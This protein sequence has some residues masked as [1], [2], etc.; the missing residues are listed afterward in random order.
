[1]MTA[2]QLL[3]FDATRKYDDDGNPDYNMR[4]RILLALRFFDWATNEEISDYLGFELRAG[5]VDSQNYHQHMCRLVKLGHVKR[6]GHKGASEY[7]L[8]LRVKPAPMVKR[9]G[10]LG[11][12]KPR[13]ITPTTCRKCRA[14]RADGRQ[15][16]V[17][18]LEWD[19]LRNQ[20]NRRAA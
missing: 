18:H 2:R 5:D 4:Q 13:V 3:G 6:R 15:L 19:R 9:G 11:G 17:N 14:P 20:E 12:R 16:C 8:A 10:D 1:M 7:Q